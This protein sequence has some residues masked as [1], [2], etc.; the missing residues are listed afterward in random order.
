MKEMLE[1][2]SVTAQ[3]VQEKQET[4]NESTF[5]LEFLNLDL[6]VLLFL[7]LK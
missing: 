2:E 5:S 3:A 7:F 6:L 4:I 1:N